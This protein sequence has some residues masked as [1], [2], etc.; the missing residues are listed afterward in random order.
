[1][2]MSI[3]PASPPD[4]FVETVVQ[5]RTWRLSRPADLESLWD[6]LGQDQFGDD[7]RLPYWVELWPAT[8]ALCGWRARQEL[9]GRRCLDLG[10]GLGLSALQASSLGAQVVGMDFERDALRFAARNARIHAISSPL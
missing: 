9:R 3:V 10:C 5:G 7:E 2:T 8:L 1:M 6:S 4:G